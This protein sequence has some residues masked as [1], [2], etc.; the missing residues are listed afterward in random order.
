MRV[1]N[2]HTTPIEK[3][4]K[5]GVYGAMAF[6]GIFLTAFIIWSVACMGGAIYNLMTAA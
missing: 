2:I 1:E 4:Y 3:T 5:A 6:C